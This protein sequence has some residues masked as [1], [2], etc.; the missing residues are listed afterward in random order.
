MQRMIF[1]LLLLAFICSGCAAVL[2]GGLIY[3]STKSKEE[4]A[5]FLRWFHE[6]NAERESKGLKPL[7]LCEE[8]YHFDPRWAWEQPEC[9][10]LFKEQA[11]STSG[12]T[13]DWKAMRGEALISF[14]DRAM[15]ARRIPPTGAV[16]ARA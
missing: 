11:D 6:T 14:K 4:K 13:V 12:A 15:S 1:A 16:K 3:K 9:R 5:E 7:I 10:Y 2:V 8:M